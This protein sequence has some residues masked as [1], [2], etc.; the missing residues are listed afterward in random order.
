MIFQQISLDLEEKHQIFLHNK[1][2]WE[3]VVSLYVLVYWPFKDK[4]YCRGVLNRA[5]MLCFWNEACHWM[6]KTYSL[7]IVEPFCY[8][9]MYPQHQLYRSGVQGI[10]LLLLKCCSSKIFSAFYV[11]DKNKIYVSNLWKNGVAGLFHNK[12]LWILFP[13]LGHQRLLSHK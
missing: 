8:F 2:K 5:T 3:N 1:G 9:I 13:L 12:T 4:I 10:A 11:S 7:L 6:T